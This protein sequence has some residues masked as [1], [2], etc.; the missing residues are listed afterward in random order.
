M[1]KNK[2]QGKKRGQKD[3]EG[4]ILIA[5]RDIGEMGN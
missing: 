3:T 1:M 5:Q 4:D 2:G